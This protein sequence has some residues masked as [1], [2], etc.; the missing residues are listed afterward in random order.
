M[1][2]IHGLS[3]CKKGE[4]SKETEDD[5]DV[6]VRVIDC[7]DAFVALRIGNHPNSARMTSEECRYI[8]ELLID[9]AGRADRRS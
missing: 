9:A 7:A 3:G 1:R 2:F 5:G 6:S 4:G 8:A